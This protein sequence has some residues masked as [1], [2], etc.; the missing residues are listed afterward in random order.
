MLRPLRDVG[1]VLDW[2]VGDRLDEVDRAMLVRLPMAIDVRLQHDARL[3]GQSVRHARTV[4]IACRRSRDS[5]RNGL[6]PERRDAWAWPDQDSATMGTLQSGECESAEL[7]LPTLTRRMLRRDRNEIHRLGREPT[8]RNDYANTLDLEERRRC[9]IRLR[10]PVPTRPGR[11]L[12]R[13]TPSGPS[14]RNR[15]RPRRSAAPVPGSP[16]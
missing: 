11:P 3:P 4:A 5:R 13:R 1:P 10:T 12:P 14:P 6:A 8:S 16:S 9:V 2:S 7:S 15:Q